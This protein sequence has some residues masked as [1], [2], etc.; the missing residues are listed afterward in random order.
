MKVR[1]REGRGKS[2]SV[3]GLIRWSLQAAAEAAEGEESSPNA[4]F[5]VLDPIGECADA[6]SGLP[7]D[8][9]VFR[10]EADDDSAVALTVPA[11]MWNSDAGMLHRHHQ[12]SPLAEAAEAAAGGAGQ[13]SE[14][15]RRPGDGVSERP[16]HR[17]HPAPSRREPLATHGLARGTDFRARRLSGR[18]AAHCGGMGGV[19]G[20][21]TTFS[22]GV[23]A[24]GQTRWTRA[25]SGRVLDGRSKRSK[26]GASC[27]P[28]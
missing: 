25:A 20:G 24:V 13:P 19:G 27:R 2:C 16:S 23:R 9:R 17:R 18:I 1:L 26:G 7:C 11:W 5:I 6:L 8:T 3:A 21:T 10:A 22:V 14:G 28:T 4:R 15:R 12:R